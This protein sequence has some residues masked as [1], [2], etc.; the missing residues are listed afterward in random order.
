M[1]NGDILNKLIK[2]LITILYPP[3]CHGCA[4]IVSAYGTICSDCWKDLQF[5]TKPYCPV[6]GTPFAYDM[7]EGF[8]SGEAIQNSPPFSSL[9]S[10]VVHKGLAR[11]LVTRLKYGDRLELAS[12][13]ANSMIF[14][15]HEIINDCDFIIPIPLHFRRF[16]VRRYNQSAELARYIAEKQK[17][18]FKPG[19]LVRYRYTRPQVGLSAKERKMNVQ[20]AFKVPN[21]V[22]KYL[23][24]RSI[25][26]IDD[27]L[28]TGVTVTAATKTLKHAGAR[29]VNVLTF[30]RVLKGNF[31]LPYF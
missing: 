17:K 12:F 19:W 25:L 31:T 20:N 3:I 23:E 21:K 13:M 11:T 30:S 24:G 9:R 6:M 16:F 22:K 29:Q 27:V 4:K 18:P 10:A 8:L 1:I 28:T 7:G 15:G 26:L 2:R 14:A 5:I